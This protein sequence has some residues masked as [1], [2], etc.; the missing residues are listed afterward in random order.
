MASNNF[1]H[2]ALG[3]I[4]S[5]SDHQQPSLHQRRLFLEN[6]ED[7]RLLA[8]DLTTFVCPAPVAPHG[9]DD[10]HDHDDDHGVAFLS[11]SMEH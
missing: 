3:K 1:L 5:Q 9:A 10:D 7:R 4:L 8:A 11:S 6:L 2:R